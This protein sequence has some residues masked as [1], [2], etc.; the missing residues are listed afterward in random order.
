[1]SITRPHPDLISST[2][3]ELLTAWR[4]RAPDAIALLAPEREP[5]TYGELAHQ[6]DVVIRAMAAHGVGR[7]DRVAL[8]LPAGPDCAAATLSITGVCAV[9][10]LHP[11]FT[12]EECFVALT[13]LRARALVVQAGAPSPA[14][15]AAERRGI[16][17]IDLTP[18]A[19]AGAFA[20]SRG[21]RSTVAASPPVGA[22][23][24][25]LVLHTSGTTAEAKRVPLSHANLLASA[26]ANVGANALVSDDRALHIIPLH[27]AEGISLLLGALVAGASIVCTAGFD[28]RRFFDWL[29]KFQPTY[30]QGVAPMH[31]DILR[32]APRHWETIARCSLRFVRSG[33]S[34]L[35]VSTLADLEATFGVLVSEGYGMTETAP[36]LANTPFPPRPRKPG[37]VGVAVGCEMA[38]A[39]D[40]GRHLSVG[41]TGEVVVRGPNVMAGY[42]DDPAAT[43]AAFWPDGWFR[44]GDQGH[45]DADG[46]LF[47][48]GR[49][50]EMINRGGENV[51]PRVVE[52]ALLLQPGVLEA[53]AFPMPDAR[54]GEAV[55]AAVVL[56]PGG[57]TSE[58]ELIDRAAEHLAP[59]Y[60]PQRIFVVDAIPVGPTG[61][62]RRD[63]V[64][65]VVSRPSSPV[66]A[67]DEEDHAAPRTETERRV[68]A[69]FGRL[70]EVETIGRHDN[71]FHLG[72]D[73][74]MVARAIRRTANTL[75]VVLPP[76]A[77]FE[78]PTVA[79]FAAR[80]EA[81]PAIA[82]GGDEQGGSVLVPLQPLG[83]RRP[84]FIIP[85]GH[86]G[87]RALV[88]FAYLARLVGTDQPCYGFL[89]EESETVEDGADPDRWLAMT[90]DR[91]V[92]MIRQR[93]P[94]G[95]YVIAGGCIGGV[96]AVEVARR[97]LADGDQIAAL[98]LLD[99]RHPSIAR[100][101]PDDD[102]MPD[103]ESPPAP[104][105]SMRPGRRVQFSAHDRHQP[106]RETARPS[107][108]WTRAIER[109]APR[110]GALADRRPA[111]ATSTLSSHPR[112]RNRRAK[113][114]NSVS[115]RP[116]PGSFV[117][118]VNQEWHDQHPVLGWEEH[119]QGS[120]EVEVM[121][122]SHS[123]YLI[124]HMEAVATRLRHCLD[125]AQDLASTVT[126]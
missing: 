55:A 57:S 48:T 86:G 85:G 42:D 44:T 31:V 107:A 69:L 10:P 29:D 41:E 37:S 63:L 124:D 93:Q 81:T 102:E 118:F 26:R 68:A 53:I 119:A 110:L 23:D 111:V 89:S 59:S 38:I 3:P 104:N 36:V 103:P 33:G 76:H 80:I 113:I 52:A 117:L 16:A 6:M 120:I 11:T 32:N 65:Q 49:L 83:T 126:R 88:R 91:Y 71:F 105:S 77:L 30:Y 1:M 82:S 5:L 7:G 64:A 96:I 72:G 99:T 8:S 116:Y 92:E 40:R 61:K 106:A 67:S 46:Y 20:L 109:V 18:S 2:I 94:D 17:V 24:I 108:P 121:P 112:R 58:A 60:V 34:A 90:A 4:E 79:S 100:G 39:D 51:A 66:S 98:I 125:A 50:K 122:G 87:S 56:Q 21:T 74:L 84:L 78:S 114:L 43:E 47:L 25:S 123:R 101:L 14:R 19:Q 13:N 54:L 9:A 28:V 22:N 75:G 115:P 35:P 73:S 97:L 45:L 27:H 70:L 95:P 12:P 62:P 15:T